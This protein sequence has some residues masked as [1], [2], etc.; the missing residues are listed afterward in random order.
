[1]ILGTL[2]VEVGLVVRH[3]CGPEHRILHFLLYVGF[4]VIIY[5]LQTPVSIASEFNALALLQHA[6]EIAVK[7]TTMLSIYLVISL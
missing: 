4:F 5:L 7:D 6:A 3:L 2:V 1:M